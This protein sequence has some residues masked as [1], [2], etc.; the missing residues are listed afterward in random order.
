MNG[1]I[2][3]DKPKG[4]TSFDVIAKMRGASKT[5]KIGHGGTLDPMATGVLPLF[6]G[7]AAK[8]CDLLPIQDK[9][10]RATFQLGLTT[11]TYDITGTVT[12]QKE[13][14]I[15]TEQQLK[16]VLTQFV[17]TIDQIPPMYSAIQKDGVRLY[18]LARQG[19]TVKRQPRKITIYTLQLQ[20]FTGQYFTV[21]ISCSKGTYVRSLGY[22][23]GQ[24]LGCGATMVEL[25]RTASS[26]FGL[27]DCLTLE[28][29]LQL[30]VEGKL[31]E[32]L[33]SVD[34]L[35]LSLPKLQLNEQ[36]SILFLNGAILDI[37]RIAQPIPAG[38]VRVYSNSNQFLGIA[39]VN[40]ETAE[41]L[42]KKLFALKEVQR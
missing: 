6:F 5:R 27:E 14:P 33:L 23:I 8:V 31:A 17:G 19:I 29:A 12:A 38:D 28:T 37:N 24:V 21:D 11:D 22:D 30:A 3:I 39:T 7:R 25:Q 34:R 26:G 9:G 41:L 40:T 1:I 18:D 36:Q 10:Y 35:F 4:F 13:V 16:T 42:I 2:C 32:R 20:S 15:L